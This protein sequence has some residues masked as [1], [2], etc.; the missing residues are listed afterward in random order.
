MTGTAGWLLLAGTALFFTAAFAPV[1]FVFG[2]ESAKQRAFLAGRERSWRWVQL[3]CRLRARD[4]EAF[5][6]GGLPGWHYR[7]Y[8]W[9]TLLALAAT[10]LAA[11]HTDLPGWSGWFVLVATGLLALAWL[12]FRDLPPF[13]FYVVTG[14]LGVAAM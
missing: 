2:M 7:V 13:L 11:L 4:P 14:V 3:P 9:G 1:S 10:G 12:A 8:V 5:L 6:D